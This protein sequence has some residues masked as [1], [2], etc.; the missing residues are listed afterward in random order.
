M[1]QIIKADMERQGHKAW[2]IVATRGNVVEVAFGA[3]NA[4]AYY[5]FKDGVLVDVQYD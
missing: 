4:A 2:R 1:E 5:I 3:Y